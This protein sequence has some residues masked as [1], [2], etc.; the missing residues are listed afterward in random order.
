MYK[1]DII[2]MAEYNFLSIF[3]IVV[4]YNKSIDAEK[5]IKLNYSL[6]ADWYTSQAIHLVKYHSYLL[7]I[8]L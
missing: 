6:V 8:K 1:Q 4:C 7:W 2:S 3:Y 5:T